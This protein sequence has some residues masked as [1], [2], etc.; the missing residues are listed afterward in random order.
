MPIFQ[1]RKVRPEQWSQVAHDCTTVSGESQGLN[2][3]CLNP[4]IRLQGNQGTAFPPLRGWKSWYDQPSAPVSRHP[5][6]EKP[7]S[8]TSLFLTVSYTLSHDSVKLSS[9][10]ARTLFLQGS[11]GL[12]LGG[13]GGQG[14]GWRARNQHISN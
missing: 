2:P 9:F 12:M 8:Q 14:K 10:P 3:G 11:E 13:W 6:R 4:M 7:P 5:P 1:M